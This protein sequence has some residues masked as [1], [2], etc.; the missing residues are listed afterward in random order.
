MTYKQVYL[1]V[2]RKK[3]RVRGGEGLKVQQNNRASIIKY[4]HQPA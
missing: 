2:K 3:K 1:S 4:K